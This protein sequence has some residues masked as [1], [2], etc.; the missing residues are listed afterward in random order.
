M[1]ILFA[2][3]PCSLLLAIVGVIVFIWST[4]RGQ[5]DDLETPAIRMLYDELPEKNNVLNE[6]VESENLSLTKKDGK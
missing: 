4:K 3:L 5:F 1:E 6:G 2:L